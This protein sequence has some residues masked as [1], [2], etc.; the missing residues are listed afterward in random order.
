[1]Q[2]REFVGAM[3]AAAYGRVL[4]A[5]E[6]V[7]CG[8]IGSGGRGQLLAG[9]FLANGA[10]VAAVCDVYE[11]NLS[12][13]LKKASPGAKGYGEYRRVLDDTSLDAVVVAAPDHWHSRMMIDA[14]DAGKDVYQEKP[15]AHTIEDGE[16][17][18]RAV[19]RTRRVVQVGTQRR[20]FDFFIEAKALMEKLGQVRLVTSWWANYQPALPAGK[21]EG[22]L[23]W[24]AW[25][26]SAPQRPPDP[27]R[28]FNWYWF[29]DYGGGLLVGQ[30]AHLMDAIQWF[31]KS[32]EPRAVT[33]SAGRVNVEGAEVPETCVLTVEFPEDY[34][35][36]FAI[37]YQA[38]RYNFFNDQL[39]Q[40]H[41]TAARFDVA[42]EWCKL[43][44]QSREI[45]LKAVA[46]RRD[47]GSFN[48]RATRQHVAN[49]LECVKSR[50]EPNAPVEAG[51]AT[52]IVLGMA[53]ESMRTGRRLIWNKA[54]R[55]AVSS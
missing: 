21:F 28:F 1:M 55:R 48:G 18:V 36:T 27:V 14:V 5:N 22:A 16:A 7:R 34:L 39:K 2:R 10:E 12:A 29:W 47:P 20:S 9:E 23:D 53:V 8:V 4:G 40:F 37:G 24:K 11:P 26:G 6:R 51:Q 15:L 35:A 50:K 25:L 31:M 54:E 42:R 32:G 13:G 33:C 52:N 45:E 19:R 30:A 46:E 43:Y 17:K 41:G 38:M 49:F 3:A 44:P